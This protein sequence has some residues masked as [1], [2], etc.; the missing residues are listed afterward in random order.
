MSP[1]V[2]CNVMGLQDDSLGEEI[3]LW[4]PLNQ[5]GNRIDD[6]RAVETVAWCGQCVV[7]AWLHYLGWLC[8][9]DTMPPW[10]HHQSSLTYLNNLTTCPPSDR[11]NLLQIRQQIAP[12]L[13]CVSQYL[14][15]SMSDRSG[16]PGPIDKRLHKE[17]GYQPTDPAG[18]STGI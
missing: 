13:G 10:P 8:W 3:V 16:H 6:C 12:R 14:L 2:S 17:G 11:H 18:G 7:V 15:V 4:G 1:L 5:I 9:P